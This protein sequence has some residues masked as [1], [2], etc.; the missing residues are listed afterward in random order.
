VAVAAAVSFVSSTFILRVTDRELA[1]D[2]EEAK[3][4]S[5]AQKG[6]KPRPQEA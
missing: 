3:A 1:I 6:V 4:K 5:K 2:V